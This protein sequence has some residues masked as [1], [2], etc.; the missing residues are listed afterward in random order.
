M[1]PRRKVEKNSQLHCRRYF[2]FSL[3]SFSSADFYTTKLSPSRILWYHSFSG[4]SSRLL[5]P[6]TEHPAPQPV[7]KAELEVEAEAVLEEEEAAAV[8]VG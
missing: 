3:S 5:P 7:E 4:G 2:Y 6:G 8:R 1:V